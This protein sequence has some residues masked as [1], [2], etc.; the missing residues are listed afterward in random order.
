MSDLTRALAWAQRWL[1]GY[2]TDETDETG[3]DAVCRALL[4]E[5][6]RADCAETCAA[7]LKYEADSLASQVAAA[8]TVIEEQRKLLRE[9]EERGNEWKRAYEANA[10]DARRWRAVREYL[11]ILDD[12]EEVAWTLTTN[13][14]STLPGGW[15]PY[16]RPESVDAA[17][18]ALADQ[19]D[20]QP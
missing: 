2:P 13:L 20:A 7:N 3:I 8:T 4:A 19:R 5:H 17:A 11:M 12:P 18:D 10:A 9:E 14:K 15:E 6:E 1:D 16:P